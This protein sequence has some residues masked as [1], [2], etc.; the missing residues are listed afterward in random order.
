MDNHEATLQARID[1]L[2]GQVMATQAAIRALIACH[3]EP[4]KA[5]AT[6]CE[7]LDRFAGIA[8][9]G[10][11]PDEMTN[12]LATA[13]HRLIPSDDELPPGQREGPKTPPREAGRDGFHS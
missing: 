5:I 1:M 11:W 8:L 7:H 2:Q 3:P 9:A 4:E 13:Q 12:A 6:V 10:H